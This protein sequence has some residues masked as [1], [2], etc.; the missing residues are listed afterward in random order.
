MAT[1]NGF[2]VKRFGSPR[3]MGLKRVVRAPQRKDA[4]ERYQ[5][6]FVVHIFRPDCS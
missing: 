2:E 6:D 4:G 3:V 5:G 1:G